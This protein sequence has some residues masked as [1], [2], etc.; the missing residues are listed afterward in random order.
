MV[1]TGAIM[2]LIASVMG[3]S[4]QWG[5]FFVFMLLGCA[6]LVIGDD[7]TSGGC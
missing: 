7:N 6:A 5:L 1:S 3:F 4:G 2:F